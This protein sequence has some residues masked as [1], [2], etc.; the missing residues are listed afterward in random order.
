MYGLERLKDMVYT[1][2]IFV[3][4]NEDHMVERHGS[5]VRDREVGRI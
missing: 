1:G 4:E 2:E 3:T 5:A